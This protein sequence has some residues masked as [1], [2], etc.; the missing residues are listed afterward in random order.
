VITL[1][2]HRDFAEWLHA[3]RDAHGKA[4]ILMRLR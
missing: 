3:L 2:E 4:R 1:I